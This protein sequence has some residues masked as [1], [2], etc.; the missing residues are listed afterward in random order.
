MPL[1]QPAGLLAMASL[2]PTTYA[3]QRSGGSSDPLL[4]FWISSEGITTV[5]LATSRNMAQKAADL[6]KDTGYRYLQA[7]CLPVL[8]AEEQ[9]A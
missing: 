5:D 8:R 4:R 3:V 9:Y 7:L 2:E 6:L 1:R